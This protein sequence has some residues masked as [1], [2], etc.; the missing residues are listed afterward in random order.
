MRFRLSPDVVIALGA[1]V[2]QPGEEMA[3]EDVELVARHQPPDEMPPYERLLGDAIE[4]DP[5][6]FAREDAVEAAWRV[7]DPIL[8]EATPVLTRTTRDLGPAEADR[9]MAGIG[10][11]HD[12]LPSEPST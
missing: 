6:L 8:D 4:G 9:L 3:G 2:K 7:V 5:T 11:W 10:S 1:R 12:P